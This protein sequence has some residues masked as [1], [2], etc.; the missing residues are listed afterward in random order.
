M[1][2]YFILLGAFFSMVLL[3]FLPGLIELMRPR[4]AGPLKLDLDRDIDERY[5]ARAFRGY[6]RESLIEAGAPISGGESVVAPPPLSKTISIH[7]GPEKVLLNLG[8]LEI[9]DK[10]Q[11]DQVIVVEGDFTTGD[12]CLLKAEV[13]A[14]G[15][16]RLGIRNHAIAVCGGNVS[17]GEETVVAGWADAE[18]ELEI[19]RDCHIDSRAT[20]GELITIKGECALKSLAAPKIEVIISD[21]SKFTEKPDLA[22]PGWSIEIDKYIRDKF[23]EMSVIAIAKEIERRSPGPVSYNA[24][25]R[26]MRSLGLTDDA[27]MQLSDA[28]KPDFFWENKVWLQGGT[29]LRVRGNVRIPRGTHIPGNLIFEGDLVTDQNVI[30]EGSVHVRGDARFGKGNRLE[31]TLVSDG[32]ITLEDGCVVGMLAAA[33][34]NLTAK[35]N[36]KIGNGGGGGLSSQEIVFLSKNTLIHGKVYGKH[37]IRVVNSD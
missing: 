10:T 9:N 25:L 15:D 31:E 34:G 6:L 33:D 27:L 28:Q 21:K 23:K 18:G 14:E 3:S 32:D 24:V 1:I 29:T 2:N 19:G 30:F 12:S 5:F 37:G 26:R 22:E 35:E 11:N 16:C 7:R 13:M 4:D 36:I 20:A 8:N 17:L